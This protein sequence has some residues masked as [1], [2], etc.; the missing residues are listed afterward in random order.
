[1]IESRALQ[2]AIKEADG[3]IIVDIMK[4]KQAANPRFYFEYQ[5][6]ENDKLI[7]IFWANSICKKNYSSCVF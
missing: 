4:S 3:Q 7:N 1:M 6:D 5:V 2:R